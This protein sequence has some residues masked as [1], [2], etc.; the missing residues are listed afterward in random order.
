MRA[1]NIATKKYGQNKTRKQ[2]GQI[3]EKISND[4]MRKNALKYGAIFTEGK[5]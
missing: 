2:I 4:W 1:T 3:I 5:I